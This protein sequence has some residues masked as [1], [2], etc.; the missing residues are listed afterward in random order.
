MPLLHPQRLVPLGLAALLLGAAAESRAADRPP[1]RDAD[2][3]AIADRV[4]VALQPAWDAR[5]G[6]VRL[7]LAG[8]RRAHEREH[9]RRPRARRASSP[10]RPGPR[11]RARAAAR[12]PHDPRADG[13]P[14]RPGRAPSLGLLDRAARQLEDRPHLGRP[15]DRRGARRGLVRTPCARPL[16][17]PAR[18]HP[19]R[20]AAL[21]APHAVALPV[22]AAQP[23]Q[24]E[25]PAL[26]APRA[27]DGPPQ[28]APARLPAPSHAVHRRLPAPAPRPAHVEPRPRI[29]LPLQP[30]PVAVRRAQLRHARVREP[31]RLRLR[32][33]TRAPARPGCA[34]CR[35]ATCAASARG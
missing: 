27:P 8:R 1:L 26:R 9:A 18:C 24:L 17:R 21:R 4:V 32:R 12:R 2:Y 19:R 10:P 13:A 25:R 16:P 35:T 30:L 7:R 14:W 20:R 28:P 3:W 34:R 23:D 5:R 29:R 11:G 15:A 33:T 22:R 6:R 31:R